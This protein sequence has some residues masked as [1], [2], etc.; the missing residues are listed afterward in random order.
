MPCFTKG[1][2]REENEVTFS[3]Q[4]GD[5]MY[6]FINFTKYKSSCSQVSYKITTL[7]ILEKSAGAYPWW[8]SMPVKLQTFPQFYWSRTLP[9]IISW[10]FSKYS[11]QLF[12]YNTSGWLLLDLRVSSSS[13]RN[14]KVC[15]ILEYK[16]EKILG[17]LFRILHTAL[18]SLENYELTGLQLSLSLAHKSKLAELQTRNI[19]ACKSQL[20]GLLQCDRL[21]TR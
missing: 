5:A 6:A 17:I 7:E 10:I 3:D 1:K 16:I 19:L 8:S 20:I 4:S 14:V 11:E 2:P 13:G 21:A 15:K 9:W 18:C 12:S